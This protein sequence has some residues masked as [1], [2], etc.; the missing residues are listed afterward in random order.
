MSMGGYPVPPR[1]M[2]ANF[3][4]AMAPQMFGFPLVFPNQPSAAAAAAAQTVGAVP[5]PGTAQTAGA[6]AQRIARYPVMPGMAATPFPWWPFAQQQVAQATMM[7]GRRAVPRALSAQQ[8][9]PLPGGAPVVGAP[10]GKPVAAPGVPAAAAGRA[11]Q[12]QATIRNPPKVCFSVIAAHP[13]P[14]C[15]PATQPV[16]AVPTPAPVTL[17]APAES[18]FPAQDL[19][20]SLRACTNPAEQKQQIGE[21]LFPLVQKDNPELAGK[22][23]GL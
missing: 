1:G 4:A 12:Y 2:P 9:P 22:I 6:A 5:A 8:R 7:G 3:A 21:Y 18:S 13:H 20:S 19:L 11:V 14:L 10:A 23:T 17:A 16:E 15:V